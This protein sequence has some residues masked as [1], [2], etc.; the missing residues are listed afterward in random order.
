MGQTQPGKKTFCP[1][2]HDAGGS[3][4]KNWFLY[5]YEGKKRI[6]KYGKINR[7]KTEAGRRAAAAALVDELAKSYQPPPPNEA[8]KS[9]L[10]AA[11]EDH[12]PTIRGKTYSTYKTKLNNLFAFL[13]GRPVTTENLRLYF[14]EAVTIRHQTTVHDTYRMLFRVFKLAGLEHLLKPIQV[15]KGKSSPLRYFQPHQARQTDWPQHLWPKT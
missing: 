15:K 9:A 3:L 14:K 8:E 1:E 13:K 6:R 7:E 11:L 4:E 2:L 5:W 10:Y 12:R